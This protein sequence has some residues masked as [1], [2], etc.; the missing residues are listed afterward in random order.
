MI[1]YLT[2]WLTARA[3][4]SGTPGMTMIVSYSPARTHDGDTTRSCVTVDRNI[5][6]RPESVST[7]VCNVVPDT[8]LRRPCISITASPFWNPSGL[9][10]AYTDGRS[11]YEPTNTTYLPCAKASALLSLSTHARCTRGALDAGLSTFSS[12]IANALHRGGRNAS[13]SPCM[14]RLSMV[15]AIAN[16]SSGARCASSKTAG[17]DTWRRCV[18]AGTDLKL[19]ACGAIS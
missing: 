6:R 1:I 10:W 14:S 15:H 13:G 11:V 8:I 9:K 2:L 3:T 18:T 5:I 19:Q 16:H 12:S 17:V 7:W 4:D